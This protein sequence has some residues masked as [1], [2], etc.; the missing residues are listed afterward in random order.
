MGVQR[1][2][3]MRQFMR[4]H[5][6]LPKPAPAVGCWI[7]PPILEPGAERGLV[8]GTMAYL[9]PSPVHAHRLLIEIL[10]HIRDGSADFPMHSVPL[11]VGR[12]A[13][14]IDSDVEA[15]IFQGLD[16]LRDEGFGQPR[17]AFENEGDG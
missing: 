9:T 14:G 5:E 1:R 12:V 16:L 2:D 15:A 11:E 7:P 4:Q 8:A 3:I 6:R 13:Q 17:I 10:R